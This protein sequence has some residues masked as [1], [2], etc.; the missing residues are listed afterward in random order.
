[1]TKA[2]DHDE[3]R[4]EILHKALLLIG[5][6]GYKNVKCQQVAD[7]CG[8]SRTTL[9]K[10]YKDMREIFDCALLS[11]VNKI[12]EDFNNSVREQ[13]DIGSLEKV[14]ILCQKVLET[15]DKNPPLL[16]AIVEYLVDLRRR[17]EPVERRLRRHT[18]GLYRLLSFL[19][20]EG[21]QNGE[22]RNVDCR[23]AGE[24]LYSML[25]SASLRLTLVE[26]F[27]RDAFMSQIDLILGGLKA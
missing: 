3:R 4:A 26:D 7:S 5:E 18:I 16:G 15:M 9:Y 2:V 14:R 8:V 17:N 10:Y 19:I 25:E 24:T 11:M 23:C 1:M 22:I 27:D 21:I 12:G 20:R 6:R 13:Q